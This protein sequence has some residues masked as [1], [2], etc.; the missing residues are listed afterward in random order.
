MDP[1]ALK[2]VV[3]YVL[4][5]CLIISFNALGPSIATDCTDDSGRET[6]KEIYE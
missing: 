5:T 3:R 2:E 1:R 4:T 6:V